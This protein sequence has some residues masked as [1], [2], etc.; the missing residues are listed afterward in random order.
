MQ[1]ASKMARQRADLHLELNDWVD[2]S[3]KSDRY[4][5]GN[6]FLQE[7]TEKADSAWATYV[8]YFLKNKI[9]S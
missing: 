3:S 8:S 1:Q 6:M 7:L 2:F 5:S 4:I 9:Q